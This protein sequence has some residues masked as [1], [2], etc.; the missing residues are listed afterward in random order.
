MGIV[1]EVFLGLGIVSSILTL[2]DLIS[3]ETVCI[4]TAAGS[5]CKTSDVFTLPSIL[6]ILSLVAAFTGV[7]LALGFAW[8]EIVRD[9]P[10]LNSRA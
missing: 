8:R 4:S 10:S 2:Q 5:V 1:S 6:G 9:R 3:N 7:A